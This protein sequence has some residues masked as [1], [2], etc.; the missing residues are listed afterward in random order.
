M[1]LLEMGREQA[2]DLG[3]FLTLQKKTPQQT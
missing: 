3:F 2:A 1:D